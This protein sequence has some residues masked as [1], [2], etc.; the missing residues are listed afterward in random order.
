VNSQITSIALGSFDGIHIAHQKLLDHADAAVIIERNQ[1]YLTPGYKRS[2]YTNKPLFF[3]YLD[4][5]RALDAFEFVNRLKSDF[6]SLQHLV[7]GYDF[8]FGHNRSA[9]TQTLSELFDGVVQIVDEVT[10]DGVSV[11]SGV[12]RRYLQN[13][14]IFQA[15]QMLGRKYSID[16]KVIPGQ[17]I[18]AKEL[19]PTLNLLIQDYQLPSQGVYVTNTRI[20]NTWLPSVSFIGHRI[21]TDGTFAVESHIIDQHLGIITGNI[22][23]EFAARLRDNKKFDSIHE[24]MDQITSDIAEASQWI[25]R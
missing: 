9:D 15:N 25:E 2:R 24:L 10:L 20:D 8:Y 14:D 23:I 18:G 22:E 1:G 16:G 6:P 17:G 13:G 21:S 5:I 19:V 11:H 4:H 3:Y 7:V 12:I